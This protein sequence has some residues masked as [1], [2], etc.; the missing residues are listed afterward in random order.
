M[1]EVLKIST[2]YYAYNA[3]LE[4]EN[5]VSTYGEPSRLG[6]DTLHTD[7]SNICSIDDLYRIRNNLSGSYTLRRNL[8][9]KNSKDYE[10]DVINTDFT[11]GSGWTPI[12]N[13]SNKFT[14]NFNGNNKTI[15]NLTINTSSSYQG[16][17]GYVEDATIKEFNII[18]CKCYR[19]SLY[20]GFSWLCT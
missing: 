1:L 12:G 17:F 20:R 19:G 3:H 14:G 2:G 6:C 13:S 8:D 18:K 5:F 10:A 7:E 4:C 11:Q 9:F 15:S 16:L